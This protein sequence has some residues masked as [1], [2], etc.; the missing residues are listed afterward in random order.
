MVKSELIHRIAEKQSNLPLKD[1]ELS[2]NEIIT[3]MAA[4]L[5][6]HERIEIRGFGSFVLR[7]RPPRKAHNPRT[8]ERV[9]TSAKYSPH[10]K[11]GKD[12]RER[13]NQ[14]Y[15]TKII[16][17]IDEDD[18]EDNTRSKSKNRGLM[19]DGD[20]FGFFSNDDDNRF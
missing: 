18:D 15:G 3:S 14:G 11:P 2:V 8:G 9:Y 10:F 16:A 12:L 6:E 5:S 7:Y 19:N 17:A 1:I 13:V 20:D 4:A